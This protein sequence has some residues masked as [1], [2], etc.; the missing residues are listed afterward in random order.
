MDGLNSLELAKLLINCLNCIDNHVKGLFTFNEEA[1][2]SPIKLTESLEFMSAKFDNLENEI[3]GKDEKIN[4]LEKTT[5]SYKIFETESSFHV[6]W[7]TTGK[8]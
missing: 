3:K 8:V 6:K 4:Q 1:K 5:I 7:R 2:K